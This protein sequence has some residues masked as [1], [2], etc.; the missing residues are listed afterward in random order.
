MLPK[1]QDFQF[2]IKFEKNQIELPASKHFRMGI[3]SDSRAF[4]VILKK[5]HVCQKLNLSKNHMKIGFHMCL[6]RPSPKYWLRYA[7]QLGSLLLRAP[8]RGLIHANSSNQ[9]IFFVRVWLL[10]KR[11]FFFA[12]PHSHRNAM[13]SNANQNC[14]GFFWGITP[15]SRDV[16]GSSEC[17]LAGFPARKLGSSFINER[18][19]SLWCRFQ[20]ISVFSGLLRH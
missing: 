3:T 12:H 8:V 17:I 15:F 16:L 5:L 19:H 2:F 10:R 13:T 4:D 20:K 9:R 11:D 6:F 18:Q 7:G 1:S 14:S